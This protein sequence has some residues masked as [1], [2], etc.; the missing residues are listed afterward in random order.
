[1]SLSCRLLLL[2]TFVQP[3]NIAKS[4][5]LVVPGQYPEI[6]LAVDA[7]EP[8]DEILVAP[9]TYQPF[10]INGK[11]LTVRSTDLTQSVIVDGQSAQ[12]CLEI[13]DVSDPGVRIEGLPFVNG[14]NVIGSGTV[15]GGGVFIQDSHVELIDVIIENC[16]IERN[17]GPETPNSGGGGMFASGSNLN[18]ERVN[19]DNNSALINDGIR[20]SR[21]SGGGLYAESCNTSFV[22]CSISNNYAYIGTTYG[23]WHNL[24][25]YGAGASFFQSSVLARDSSFNDNEFFVL[26][27]TSSVA[28]AGSGGGG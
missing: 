24:Y 9:G 19:I 8:G 22:E 14:W 27:S 15:R 6:Q 21:L 28:V 18:F 7:A 20:G 16:R 5:Q 17:T 12:R 3:K 2:I 26:N 25:G 4:E 11:S 10:S 23:S 1:M 13:Y